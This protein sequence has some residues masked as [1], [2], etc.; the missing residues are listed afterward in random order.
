MKKQLHLCLAAFLLLCSAGQAW[1]A[2]QIVKFDFSD[3]KQ[4]TTEETDKV[5]WT[6]GTSTFTMNDKNTN[7]SNPLRIY[8]GKTGTIATGE[9]LY[10]KQVVVYANSG[11][12]APTSDNLTWTNASAVVEDKKVTLTPSGDNVATIGYAAVKQI[13]LDSIVCTLVEACNEPT[14]VLAVTPAKVSLEVG[15]SLKLTLSGGN[16]AAATYSSSASD[17]V[18]VSDDGLLTPL[19]KGEAVITVAQ[20]RTGDYCSQSVE[21]SVTVTETYTVTWQTPTG[22]T[23]AKVDKGAAIGAAYPAAEV[24]SCNAD[25]YP[26][27]AGWITD[28]VG[29]TESTAVTFVT[30][31]TV[32]ESHVTYYAAFADKQKEKGNDFS[33]EGSL[34]SLTTA[35]GS[36]QNCESYDSGSYAIKMASD[37]AYITVPVTNPETAT[38]KYNRKS[39]AVTA[40]VELQYTLDN[41][42]FTLLETWNV[43][44]AETTNVIT[45]TNSKPFPQGTKSVRFVYRKT[46]GNIAVGPISV[47]A[48]TAFPS[49]TVFVTACCDAWT[50]TPSI[51]L[52]AKT[53]DADKSETLSVNEVSGVPRGYAGTVS[54][55]S[56]NPL[57]ATVEAN[58]GAATA[59]NAGTF[60][61]IATWSGDANFCDN[62]VASDEVTVTG[63][64]SIEY[65]KNSEDATGSMET[66]KHDLNAEVT[67]AKCT[68]ERKGYH[69]VGWAEQ[70]DGAKLWNDG[71]KVTLIA[72]KQLYA[73]WEINTYTITKG[74]EENGTFTL[75]AETVQH[76]GRVVVVTKTPAANYKGGVVSVVPLYS[77]TIDKD[78][79]KNI[80]D[81]ITI[82][83]TF[84][85]KTK[86]T[87]TWHDG[88][89]TTETTVYEGDAIG[90]LPASKGACDPNFPEFCGWSETSYGSS[91]APKTEAPTLIDAALKPTADAHF[92]AVYADGVDGGGQKMSALPVGS[93]VLVV[94]VDSV[95][96]GGIEKVKDKSI[97]TATKYDNAPAGL[98][99]LN[100]VAGSADGSFAFEHDGQ[101]L[102][103]SGSD[104]ELLQSTTLDEA[105]S[106]TVTFSDGNAILANVKYATRK[107]Q[108]NASQSRFACYTSDQKPIQ[109][110]RVGKQVTQWITECCT[111]KP[112]T[113]RDTILLLDENSRPTDAVRR[114]PTAGNVTV[115]LSKL[116]D[117][118]GNGGT[119][120]YS[121][122]EESTSAKVVSTEF[123][124]TKV[125]KY[126]VIVSQKATDASICDNTYEIVVTVE[127][128]SSTIT[129]DKNDKDATGEMT[130]L[131][132]ETLTKQVLTTNAFAKVGYHFV[133]W[134]TAADGTGTVYADG[135]TLEMHNMTLYAQ[136]EINTYT[137]TL[138][139]KGEGE[140]TLPTEVKHGDSFTIEAEAATGYKFKEITIA[141]T[142]NATLNGM[143][144]ENV[145]GAITVSVTFE[146]LPAFKV[147]Y[148]DATTA[149][150][151][152]ETVYEGSFAN[153]E[154]SK[155]GCTRM[156]LE[157]F[158]AQPVADNSETFE[159]IDVT[160]VNIN[161]DTT[162]YAVY[163]LYKGDARRFDPLTTNSGK[164][165]IAAQVDD[166]KKFATGALASGK[167][168]QTENADEANVYTFAQVSDNVYTIKRGEKYVNYKPNTKGNS[169]DFQETTTASTWTIAQGT[170][171][172]WRM[173][174]TATPT[175]GWIFSTSTDKFGAYGVSNIGKGY[176]DIEIISLAAPRYSSTLDCTTVDVLGVNLPDRDTI[177]VDGT[178]TLVAEV[179]PADATDK[180]V[181]WASSDPKIAEISATTG[182]VKGLARGTVTI[183]ATTN[184]GNYTALCKLVVRQRV[185]EISLDQ[186]SISVKECDDEGVQLTA[187]VLPEDAD[188]QKV[189]W[190]SNN[191]DVALVS[192]EGKV[193]GYTPGTATITATTVDGGFTAE[194][195]VTVTA[196]VKVTSLTLDTEQLDFTLCEKDKTYQLVAT[197][198]PEDAENREVVWSSSDANVAT[199]ADG[200]VT[201]VAAGKATITAATTDGSNLKAEC[202]V[203]VTDCGDAIEYV[204]TIDGV[205]VRDGRIVV[206]QER[207]ADVRVYN[208]LGLTVAS[209]EA[210][211]TFELAVP[212]GVYVVVVGE[213]SQKVVVK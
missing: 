108:Y 123:A 158:A 157:G 100:V 94:A 185:E 78:T 147:T 169:T 142:T 105:S 122:A 21:V 175:R 126:T 146:A 163:G 209:Q 174:V 3:K 167:Y 138:D 195:L 35:G 93:K 61:V 27:F 212:Q 68:F 84:V 210:A 7:L 152:S 10:F 205:F 65:N 119:K 15:Q 75:D 97:G 115:D 90:T 82:N 42:N 180:S 128:K 107:L 110:I 144:V 104:N 77:A 24:A 89:T 69:F 213:K 48:A 99:P 22:S 200:L 203:T 31:S 79:V 182:E 173:V 16:G 52:S 46:S 198:L 55:T 56:S 194:C 92:Y 12:N 62:S 141:P 140:V 187:T 206:E 71:D 95:E 162:F 192:D 207:A 88:N 39:G 121:L 49:G 196:C 134:N 113:V 202:A 204:A 2:E 23:T 208:V 34:A 26:Y 20:A 112:F 111:P 43:T 159:A 38:F 117:G 201:P 98:Y 189:V 36:H 184:D 58:S 160:K 54:Y 197:V 70:P 171:G 59:K 28:N 80:T 161:R 51:T 170:Q 6:A 14:E 18:S 67:L 133:A 96:L 72:N 124:C 176:Y 8:A 145:T 57:V 156:P 91:S 136:W 73:L 33:C 166:T 153:P 60:R 40:S 47:T 186:T 87:M 85:E 132:A 177:D 199:V 178:K 143:S 109:L 168:A 137:I 165:K 114:V 101:Y 66:T 120:T 74:K 164:F 125:G 76:G 13:R 30:A 102:S 37:G 130:A 29:K 193:F 139:Q 81:N 41:A 1:A 183:T 44:G 32:P 172:S 190:S 116:V 127:P 103:Y 151:Y 135:A 179:L 148:R 25:K 181:T 86:Y 150:I 17:V 4:I 50:T 53:L 45:L 131:T 154:L 149:E 9:G 63:K 155:F 83:V 11:S 5:V 129:F 188:N 211:T 106:W 191:G 19:K 64:V 118:D